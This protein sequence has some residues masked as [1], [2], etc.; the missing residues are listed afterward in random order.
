MIVLIK[1]RYNLT[2]KEIKARLAL[3][4]SNNEIQA[5]AEE[6]KMINENLEHL[7]QQRTLE[8]EKKNNS[9]HNPKIL[10]NYNSCDI[11]LK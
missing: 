4:Q 2:V 5:Q 11:I 8:L 9:N 6:I 7:V 10:Q 1:T 3:Q